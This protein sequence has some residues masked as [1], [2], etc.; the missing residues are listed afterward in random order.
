MGVAL[1]TLVVG[2]L[3]L[4]SGRIIDPSEE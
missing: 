4:R 1:V 3:F 2:G